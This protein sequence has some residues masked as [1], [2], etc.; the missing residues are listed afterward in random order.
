MHATKGETSTPEVQEVNAEELQEVGFKLV[1]V[2]LDDP[3]DLNQFPE[4][5]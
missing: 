4:P 1:G 3:D 2:L 5:A